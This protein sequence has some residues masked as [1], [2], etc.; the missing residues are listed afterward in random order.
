MMKTTT[1]MLLIVMACILLSC[2]GTK[3]NSTIY[4]TKKIMTVTQAAAF[5]KSNTT[6][7]GKEIIIT[8]QSC[9]V[10]ISADNTISLSLADDAYED[11]IQNSNRA[12][13]S[14]S[15]SKQAAEYAREVPDKATVTISGK[16]SHANGKIQLADCV[17]IAQN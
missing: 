3:T 13:F 17:L 7:E 14:A 6:A 8:A 9:G 10:V 4:A 2:G 15:F 1:R 16:I 12:N 11:V 5:I